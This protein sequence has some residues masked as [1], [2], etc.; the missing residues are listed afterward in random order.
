[1]ADA[2]THL[3]SIRGVGCVTLKGF[4]PA[5]APELRA[6]MESK[7]IHFLDLPGEIRNI[8]Y[9]YAADPSDISTH[10]NPLMANWTERSKPLPSY[11]PKSTPTI[12]LL[13]KRITTEALPLIRSKPLTI[14]FPAEH[15]LQTQPQVPLITGF[16]SAT[17][18]QQIQHLSL[19]L[20]KWEWVYSIEPL[21]AALSEQH[22]LKSFHLDLRDRLK[23]KFLSGVGR[24]Y[25][26]KALHE[27]L[28]GLKAVRGVERVTIEGDLPKQ[29]YAEPLKQIM[30]T[31]ASVGVEQLPMLVGVSAT[32]AVV[33]IESCIG[34]GK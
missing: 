11:P 6:R 16:I 15:T 32:G 25:P 23:T 9:A 1:M 34:R 29:F 10:L 12:L 13:N 4:P 19:H 17:S 5:L 8:I 21:I 33:D 30:Q 2:F 31:P 27:S 20:L 22:K 26:D 18:L 14:T 7:P 28:S 3:R 24:Y